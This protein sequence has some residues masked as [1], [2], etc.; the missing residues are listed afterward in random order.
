MQQSSN[1]HVLTEFTPYTK[2]IKSI[3]VMSLSGVFLLIINYWL[4]SVV[5]LILLAGQIFSFHIIFKGRLKSTLNYYTMVEF[6]SRKKMFQHMINNLRGRDVIQS[7]D[8]TSEFCREYDRRSE[9][10]LKVF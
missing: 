9:S 8:R 1:V 7:F 5:I 3:L 6:E 4:T 10:F 2:I